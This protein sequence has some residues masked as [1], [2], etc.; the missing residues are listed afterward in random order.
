[1]KVN[2][3]LTVLVALLGCLLGYWVYSV[4]EGKA[5]DWVC[6]L[7]GTISFIAAVIPIFGLQY[8][9]FKIGVNIRSLAG[10]YLVLS[11]FVQFGFAAIKVAMPYYLIIS[12]VLLVVYLAVVYKLQ[13]M[14]DI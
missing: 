14:D 4:A 6:A 3:F 8:P 7:I 9:D 1:M 5:N 11:L 10:F 13:G 12:G 2:R